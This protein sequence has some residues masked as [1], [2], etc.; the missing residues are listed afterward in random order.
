MLYFLVNLVGTDI[1]DPD[2]LSSLSSHAWS[3]HSPVTKEP[4]AQGS[5][6]SLRSP[7]VLILYRF[8]GTQAHPLTKRGVAMTFF[9]YFPGFFSLLQ[10]GDHFWFGKWKS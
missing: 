1:S 7:S 3:P 6:Q 5:L 4:T 8:W 10:H 2:F 9:L